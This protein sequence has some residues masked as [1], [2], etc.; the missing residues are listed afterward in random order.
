MDSMKKSSAQFN[1]QPVQPFL[2]KIIQ[3]YDT[4]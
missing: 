1:L 3:L 2:D 4:T